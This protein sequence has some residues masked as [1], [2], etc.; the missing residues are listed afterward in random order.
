MRKIKLYGE[1]G[2][3]F[4]KE[5]NLNVSSPAEACRALT[6]Q[7]KGLKKYLAESHE[8]GLYFRV[9][10][11]RSEIDSIEKM[12]LSSKGDIR[13][14]PVVDGANGEFR[15]LA[16]AALIFAFSAATGGAGLFFYNTGVALA[17]G[18]AGEILTRGLIPN[19]QPNEKPDNK[20]SYTFS[21]AVNTTAQGHPVPVGYGIMI[22]GGAVISASIST[23]TLLAGKEYQTQESYKDVWSFYDSNSYQEPIPP[24]YTRRELQEHIVDEYD[25]WLYRY[26]YNESVL[27][28]R[29][30]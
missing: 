20:P 12:N 11:N 23:E 15:V 16:G 27:V 9:F 28:L 26:F 24:N 5:F 30:I 3:K 22:V 4:G 6:S 8:K 14:V 1:L 19:P 7:V 29:E 10:S 25:R 13:I 21:G 18:G 17:I 2:A